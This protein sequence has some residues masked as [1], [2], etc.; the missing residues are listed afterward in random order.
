MLDSVLCVLIAMRWRM[1][2]PSASLLLGDMT[3]GYMVVPATAPVR[4]R[5]SACAARF[6]VKVD[7]R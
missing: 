4:A 2:P 1:R 6:P 3:S 5:L 7:G